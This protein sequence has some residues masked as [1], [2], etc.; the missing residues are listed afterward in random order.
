MATETLRPNGMLVN[1]S[2][3]SV[4]CTNRWECVDE[5]AADDDDSKVWND[6]SWAY[7]YYSLSNP[8]GSGTINKITA[9]G[10]AKVTGSRGAGSLIIYLS[11]NTDNIYAFPE[12]GPYDWATYSKEYTNNP[13]TDN[14]WTWDELTNLGIGGRLQWENDQGQITQLYVVVDY[15]PPAVGR[16]FGYIFSKIYEHTKNLASRIFRIPPLVNSNNLAPG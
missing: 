7:E 10:R 16:S 13:W 3:S 6:G 4:G 5:E 9:Y 15:T 8:T 11:G 1:G 2:W 12:D 14:P